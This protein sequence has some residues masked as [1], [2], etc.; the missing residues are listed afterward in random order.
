MG[1]GRKRLPEPPAGA[2]RQWAADRALRPPMRSPGR[3]ELS[4]A[5]QREFWRLIA[6]GVTTAEAAEPSRLLFVD[7]DEFYDVLADHADITRGIFKQLV[8]GVRRLAT[9]ER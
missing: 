7:R 2:R 5:V 1:R 9:A 8:Q 3:P 6:S 4:R